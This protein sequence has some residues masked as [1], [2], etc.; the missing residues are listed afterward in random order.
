MVALVGMLATLGGVIFHFKDDI[1]RIAIKGDSSVTKVNPEDGEQKDVSV[2][3]QSHEP[4]K[5]N[6]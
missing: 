3:G 6:M 1:M 2:I 5:I 4:P